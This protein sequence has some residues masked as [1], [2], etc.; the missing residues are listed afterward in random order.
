M[1]SLSLLFFHNEASV[2]CKSLAPHDHKSRTKLINS[3]HAEYSLRLKL[4]FREMCEWLGETEPFPQIHTAQ[5]KGIIQRTGVR[6]AVTTPLLLKPEI[7]ERIRN[8]E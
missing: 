7:Q 4:L 3:A 2:Q 5:K 8:M 1:C 6:V